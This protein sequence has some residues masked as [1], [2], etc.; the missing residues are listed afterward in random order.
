MPVKSWG[1]ETVF[2]SN[3]NPASIG[4][5]NLLIEQE[6]AVIAE[7]ELGVFLPHLVLAGFEKWQVK[8]LG[9]PQIG[10]FRLVVETKSVL[11]SENFSVSYG[12]SLPNSLPALGA[13]RNGAIITWNDE[14]YILSDPLYSVVEL[15]EAYKSEPIA[16]MDERFLWWSQVRELLP[17]D[18]DVGNFLKT[19]NIVRPE[20]FTLD[21]VEENGELQLTPKFVYRTE[22]DED[23]PEPAD[24]Q[25][26]LDILPPAAQ[27]DFNSTFRQH[28]VTNAR[29]ALSDRWYVV[30]PKSVKSALQAVRDIQNEP[31]E[32]KLAFLHNPRAA[33]RNCLEGKIS[34]EAL[35]SIFVETP[36]FLN[37]RIKCLGI[38]EPKAGLFI[39]TESGQWLPQDG[40]P[41]AVG[42]PI[43]GNVYTVSTEKLS[44]LSTA[45]ETALNK[46]Q[47]LLS[48]EGTEYPVNNKALEA[49]K[50]AASLFSPP[51]KPGKPDGLPE[52]DAKKEK[53]RPLVPLIYDHIE[54]LGIIVDEKT[55]QR[56][57]EH[58]AKPNLTPGIGLHSHQIEGLAWL[59]QHWRKASP[60]AILAD[61]MGLGKTLQTLAFMNW[62]KL[63]MDNGCGHQRPFLVVAP[64]GLLKNWEAEAE[65]FL[66]PP[67]LGPLFH[68]FGARFK[69]LVDSGWVNATTE[70]K[71]AGWVMT[72][73]ETLRDKILAFTGIYWAVVAFDEAQKVK[74]PKAMV[75]DM[76]KSLKAE[77]TLPLTGTPVENSLADLWCIADLAQPGRLNT[78]KEFAWLYMPGGRA[79]ESQLKTLKDELLSPAGSE[80]MMRRSKEEHWKER[81]EKNEVIH[82]ETMPLLQA[83]A[84]TAAVNRAGAEQGKP[85]TMLKALQSLRA[86][87]LHPFMSEDLNSHEEFIDASARLKATFKLLDDIYSKREKALIFVE[88]LRMQSVL[89]EIIEQRY[90]C[91]KVM[92]ISGQVSG[93]KRQARVDEFQNNR[94]GFEV[95]ILSPKA[96]GVGL[97]LTAATHV[98]HL[99]RWWNPAV[100]D[101][102]SDRVYRIGQNRSVTIHYPVAIHPEYGEENS[103]DF[104]LHDLLNRKRYLSRALLAPPAGTNEDIT[105]LFN[106]TVES[107]EGEPQTD[108]PEDRD[109]YGSRGDVD[110]DRVDLMEPL[111]FEQWVLGRLANKGYDTKTT[112]VSGDAGA[113]GIA[114]SPPGSRL[115]SYI[116]Q[117]KHTQSGANIGHGAV[118]E[119]LRASSRYPDVPKPVVSIVVTNAKGFSRRARSLARSRGVKLF[120]KLNLNSL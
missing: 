45:M 7:D 79:E 41:Q 57:C 105:W 119:V 113:D 20:S 50:K 64:T 60:G 67:G 28:S 36:F 42:I 98:I 6:Q 95:M 18:V 62:V 101:Q 49:V 115:P 11:S 46:R 23:Q 37:E 120:S 47:S 22:T 80:L 94:E 97:N 102:C 27:Y 84:Y 17:D 117:C 40:P 82:H 71:S 44:E 19:I 13:T 8:G 34:D 59:Q 85:G 15:L 39:K 48:H 51:G 9:L 106:K 70:L 35:E 99:S 53:S 38:W 72:T 83:A 77:F 91:P 78:L 89:S 75:T 111:E 109:D 93:A 87:S 61:D 81:P 31:R 114:I 76:A 2:L 16:D 54:E 24:D 86:I 110:F 73:Y 104:M 12:F 33:L 43:N 68:A 32:Q 58:P 65:K 52:E 103:F 92:I 107:V 100:E 3:G 96:G 1:K 25:E 118:E 63:Q 108:I 69:T 88:Y 74:N 5:L 26:P 21:F 30:L 29:Y 112:P 10:P 90:G 66:A 14:E 116:I 4:A 56:V 55:G